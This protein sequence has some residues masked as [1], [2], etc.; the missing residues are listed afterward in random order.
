VGWFSREALGRLNVTPSTRKL[1][2]Q[3][4]TFR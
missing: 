4:L 1:L 3:T 2:D